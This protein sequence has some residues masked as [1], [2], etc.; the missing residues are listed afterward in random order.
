TVT[1]GDRPGGGALFRVVLPA[2]REAGAA[3]APAGQE[4]PGTFGPIAGR[5]LVI[6][7]D[8]AVAQV[9]CAQLSAAGYHATVEEEAGRAL[10][11]L[12]VGGAGIDLV[13]CDLMMKGMTGMDLADA[14]ASRAP[15][16][17][18]KVVFMTGGAFTPRARA[19]RERHAGQCVEKPFDVLAEVSRRLRRRG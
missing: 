14:L 19:F 12:A 9:L 18:A 10:E 16:Q 1:A 6:D 2:F 11:T 13:F 3:E 8:P 4:P 7:D 5:V 15:D 17:L